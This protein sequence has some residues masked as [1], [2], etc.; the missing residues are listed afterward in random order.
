LFIRFKDPL[1]LIGILL[2]VFFF[3]LT[4]YLTVLSKKLKFINL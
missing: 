2:E 3:S 4:L 1:L